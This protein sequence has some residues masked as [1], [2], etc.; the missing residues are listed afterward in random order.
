MR[1]PSFFCLLHLEEDA[2]GDQHLEVLQKMQSISTYNFEFGPAFG[3]KNGD[4][5]KL[6]IGDSII[7]S[8][9]GSCSNQAPLKCRS[10]YDILHLTT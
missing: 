10:R 9:S 2:G 3:E 7:S 6:E 1:D 8:G 4:M 5:G